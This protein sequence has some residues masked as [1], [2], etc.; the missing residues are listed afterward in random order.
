MV[1]ADA[2][3]DVRHYSTELN[4]LDGAFQAGFEQRV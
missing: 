4:L 3:Y 1:I 2:H